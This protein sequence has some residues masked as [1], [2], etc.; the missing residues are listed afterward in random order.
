MSK[1]HLFQINYPKWFTYLYTKLGT[2]QLYLVYQILPQHHQL[3]MCILQENDQKTDWICGICEN[4]A[5]DVLAKKGTQIQANPSK[6]EYGWTTAVMAPKIKDIQRKTI[7]IQMKDAQWKG[8]IN[9]FP[10]LPRKTTKLNSEQLNT[11]KVLKLYRHPP[12]LGL[13][14]VWPPVLP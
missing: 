8:T 5:A 6:S 2:Y 1:N 3:T 10:E 4:E 14:P 7:E 11:G 12:E 13:Q 9:V